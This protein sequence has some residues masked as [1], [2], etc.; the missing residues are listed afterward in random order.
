SYQLCVL[1]EHLAWVIVFCADAAPDPRRLGRD[2]AAAGRDSRGQPD[3]AGPAVPS[4]P[5]AGCDG[6]FDA[7]PMVAS[8]RDGRRRTL[9]AQVAL[10]QRTFLR[11]PR[12]WLLC[13][14]G[15]FGLVLLES[16]KTARRRAPWR[17]LRANH[18]AHG[19]CIA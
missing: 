9:A 7:V 11:G 8:G 4:R 16:I 10:P 17:G 3:L 18:S 5:H 2:R 1:P 6:R 14:L 15:S 19:E 12:R 13:R